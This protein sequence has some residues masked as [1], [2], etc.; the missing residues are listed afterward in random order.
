MWYLK[1]VLAS[2][3]VIGGSTITYLGWDFTRRVVSRP[4]IIESAASWRAEAAETFILAGILMVV[5]GFV[6]ARWFVK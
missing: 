5:L 1:T 3:I 4:R 6:T 2:C